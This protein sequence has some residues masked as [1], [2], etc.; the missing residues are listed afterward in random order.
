M[1]WRSAT[2]GRTCCNTP[3]QF[4][5]LYSLLLL[6]LVKEAESIPQEVFTKSA[7]FF[8]A[9]WSGLREIEKQYES[10]AFNLLQWEHMRQKTKIIYEYILKCVKTG[11]CYRK[12]RQGD[13]IH[14][15]F[16]PYILLLTHLIDTEHPLYWR[17][18][19]RRS[20]GELNA[21]LLYFNKERVLIGEGNGNPLQY[22]CLEYLPPVFLPSF[23]GQ[24][25]LAGYSP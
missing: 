18:W 21:A 3:D 4:L 22:S 15:F 7:P 10:W 8:P 16:L 2:L 23:H 25:S 5:L 1:T 20:S 11:N 24:R 13:L 19:R 17:P 6:L 14:L 9:L 12:L